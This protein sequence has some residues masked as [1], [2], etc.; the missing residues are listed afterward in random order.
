[1]CNE[2]EH[3]KKIR[4]REKNMRKPSKREEGKGQEQKANFKNKGKER[5]Y[6][7]DVGVFSFKRSKE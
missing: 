7:A 1:M 6:K 4:R 5:T 3:F 2:R